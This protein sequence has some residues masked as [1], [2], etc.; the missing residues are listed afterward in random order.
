MVADDDALNADLNCF[1]SVF[2]S[3]DAFEDD[4]A[5]PVFLQMLDV[6]PA[7][8]ETWED[9][10]GPLGGCGVF[11]VLDLTAVFLFELR[12]EDGIGETGCNADVVGAEEGVVAA[13]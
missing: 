13:G 8:A 3:L 7:V 5:V 1:A 2:D 6:F 4:W 11:V 10:L 9:G 12:A